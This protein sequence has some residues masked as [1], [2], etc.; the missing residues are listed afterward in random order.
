MYATSFLPKGSF[1]DRGLIRVQ[2]H[3]SFLAEEEAS[4]TGH[5]PLR[6]NFWLVPSGHGTRSRKH[7][8]LDRGRKTLD[9]RD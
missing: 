1:S 2:I 7:V 6:T 8:F 9:C 5:R 3:L 4:S